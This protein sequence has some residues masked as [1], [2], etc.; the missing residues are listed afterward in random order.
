MVQQIPT[1]AL[2]A[3]A[4]VGAAAAAAASSMK[5]TVVAK[6]PDPELATAMVAA[7]DQ[8]G[9]VMRDFLGSVVGGEAVKMW[10]ARLCTELQPD[11]FSV[12]MYEGLGP[13]YRPGDGFAGQVLRA[14]QG[15]IGE[16]DVPGLGPAET[17]SAL[18]VLAD[19]IDK[20]VL[21]HQAAVPYEAEAAEM[22]FK[23]K[24]ELNEPGA[25][26]KFHDDMVDVRLVTTLV[27]DGTVISDNTGVNWDY[28]DECGGRLPDG[29]LDGRD[30]L[31]AVREWNGRVV[32]SGELACS[33]GDV[34]VMKGGKMTTRPCLHRAPYSADAGELPRFLLTVERLH[35]DTAQQLYDM[36]C[37][38]DAC[39]DSDG[40]SDD[41]R[42][43]DGGDD[44]ADGGGGDDDDGGNN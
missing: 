14:L 12:K 19:V 11:G 29:T 10:A 42:D 41:S 38:C 17:A 44:D 31:D 1:T 25:C 26:T 3:S 22:R 43:D 15:T 18:P 5:P 40:S 34:G 9:V 27:G 20:M 39:A 23:A 32:A 30:F 8:N 28:Y 37:D 4:G 35:V 7:P 13:H 24:V 21:L 33:P 2:T 16:L 6:G 36:D